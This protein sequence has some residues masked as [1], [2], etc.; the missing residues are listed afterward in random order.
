MNFIETVKISKWSDLNDIEIAWSN[1]LFRGHSDSNWVLDVSLIRA[2]QTR[3]K[4]YPKLNL[5]DEGNVLDEYYLYKEFRRRAHEYMSLFPEN[6]DIVSWLALMQHY[7]TPT[8]L[9]DFTYSFFIALF[10]AYID[11]IGDAVIWSIDDIF[12]STTASK[13]ASA[14]DGL[15]EDWLLFQHNYANSYLK[16]CFNKSKSGKE[17]DS[18]RQGVIMLEPEKPN[19]RLGIQQG[20]FLMPMD[21]SISF[22]ENLEANYKLRSSYWTG[23]PVI[24]YILDLDLRSEALAH[25]MKMNITSETL[26]PG[27][28]GY[29]RSI[30]HKLWH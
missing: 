9:L 11:A 20:L 27:I 26:F 2:F 7:G 25:L 1:A 17:Y 4:Q 29:G 12:I 3:K 13:L 28:D 14:P 18:I 30:L 16:D 15:R 22:L 10:F 8:R 5:T 19:H 23:K 21:T 6:E 24:K